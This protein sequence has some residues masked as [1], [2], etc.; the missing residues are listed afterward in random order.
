MALRTGSPWRDLP[1]EYGPWQTAYGLFRRCQRQG[2]W[3]R[4]LTLLQARPD[5]AGL[6]TWEVSVDSMVCQDPP[7]RGRRTAGRDQA[8]GAAWRSR[9][10][11][12][13]DSH[14]QNSQARRPPRRG[15]PL[16]SRTAASGPAR[17]PTAG[18]PRRHRRPRGRPVTVGAGTCTALHR[19][20]GVS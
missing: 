15:R 4:V 19:S 11:A 5:T 14:A 13:R 20:Y 1:P 8:E 17:E 10:R 18:L 6:I 16:P 12:G 2:A 7:A 9:P 3:A